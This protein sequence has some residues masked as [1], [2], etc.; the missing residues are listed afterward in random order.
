MGIFFHVFHKFLPI[1]WSD[2]LQLQP[3]PTALNERKAEVRI[4]FK[5]T[6]TDLFSEYN[7][8]VARNELVIRVQPDEAVYMKLNTKTPGMKFETEETEL[9]LT[10]SKRY[11]VCVWHDM[12][13]GGGGVHLLCHF[14]GTQ[15]LNNICLHCGGF[16]VLRNLVNRAFS[17]IDWCIMWAH[18]GF[19]LRTWWPQ[20][21]VCQDY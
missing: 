2:F 11:Q 10:Y 5:D 7:Y 15:L 20:R 8:H 17:V 19:V 1:S 14:I 9:D 6:Y 13:M 16:I 21:A 18:G 12:I 3:H 4:Q